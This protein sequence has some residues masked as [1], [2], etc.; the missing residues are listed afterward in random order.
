MEY[1][2]YNN[3]TITV[4]TP[5]GTESVPLDVTEFVIEPLT[6]SSQWN[7]ELAN[8]SVEWTRAHTD[9]VDLNGATID[10]QPMTREDLS[11]NRKAV[12]FQYKNNSAGFSKKQQ[13]SRL[14]RGIGRQRG[15]T[16]A[17]QS[18]T[19]TNANTKVLPLNNTVLECPGV[20]KNWAYTNQNDTPGPLTTITNEPSVPLTNYIVRRTYLAG[21][22]KWPQLGWKPGMNGFPVGK[23]GEK[24]K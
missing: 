9:C 21:N 13:Y 7:P 20:A 14:A 4:T 16:F 2:T 22:N 24:I 1:G 19:Y 12:I 10:G 17:T 23:N 8:E 11:E 18:D 5:A 6:S 15:Q 3:V